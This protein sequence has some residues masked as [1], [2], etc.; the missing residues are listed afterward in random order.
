MCDELLDV[1]H[2]AHSYQVEKQSS[3]LGDAAHYI[4]IQVSAVNPGGYARFKLKSSALFSGPPL[5]PVIQHVLHF[6]QVL[7]VW[8]HFHRRARRS[9]QAPPSLP[10]PPAVPP[11]SLHKNRQD[12]AKAERRETARCPRKV[13]DRMR[14]FISEGGSGAGPSQLLQPDQKYTERQNVVGHLKG[15]T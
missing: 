15:S 14:S 3:S 4:W 5:T 13:S 2:V 12:L 10:V 6:H 1:K 11:P 9:R 8:L 7:G